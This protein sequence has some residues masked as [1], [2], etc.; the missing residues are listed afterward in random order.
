M[1]RHLLQDDAH[2][3]GVEP[4]AAVLFR[5]AEGPEARL[6]RLAREADEVFAGNLRS[7]RIEALLE[8]DDLLLDEATDLL[9]DGAQ[10]IGQREAREHGHG[11]L[12]EDAVWRRF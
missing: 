1:L 12:L 10:L 4:A 8:G 5:D 3:E 6:F 9:A 2:A 11:R 7:V